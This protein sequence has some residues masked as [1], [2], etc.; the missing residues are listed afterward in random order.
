MSVF[1]RVQIVPI[2]EPPQSMGATY[3][4]W[5]VQYC[6]AARRAGVT[7]LQVNFLALPLHPILCE[8][9]TKVY[10]WFSHYAPSL[11]QFAVSRL[12]RGVYPLPIVAAN[13]ERMRVLA[14]EALRCGLR[15]FLYCAEPRFVPE[16]FFRQRPDLRGPRVDNPVMSGTPCFALCTDKAEVREHYREMLTHILTAIP[17]ITTL[18]LFTTDSGSGFCY[19][20]DLYAGANGPGHCRR[21]PLIERIATFARE[22]IAAGRAINPEF[23]VHINSNL[24]P[25]VRAELARC[26]VDGLCL[27]VYGW[28]SWTGGLED[29]WAYY[30]YRSQIAR[31]GYE[32]ARA[33]RIADLQARVE[34][35]AVHE[36]APWAICSLPTEQY[37]LPLHYVPQPFEILRLLRT[38]RSLGVRNLSLRG[39]MTLPNQVRYDVNAATLP[40]F[41]DN[42]EADDE[43]LVATLVRSWGLERIAAPLHEAWQA[44]DL[45]M[46]RRPNWNHGFGRD[47]HYMVGPL[48][49][50]PARLTV[51]E[52]AYFDHVCFDEIYAIKG[53]LYYLPNLGSLR[54][55]EYVLNQYEAE[56]FP[57]LRQACAVLHTAITQADGEERA[58]LQEQLRYIQIIESHF[59]SQRNWIRMTY[60]MRGGHLPEEARDIVQ[61]EI[62][63]TQA[64]VDLLAG[65]PGRYL[66]LASAKGRMYELD[67]D[68]LVQWEARLL[69]MKRHLDDPLILLSE[70]AVGDGVN[71]PEMEEGTT[72]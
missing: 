55:Y 3:R 30:Q 27:P 63:N 7:E 13:F 72:V 28:Y 35:V 42:P 64:L 49:P 36:Q 37:F 45:A 59:H 56:T 9:P 41:Q 66:M 33:E 15:P 11:D 22:L 50:D 34:A 61:D 67:P 17:Q 12:F 6:A 5:A 70:A 29:Q 2:N 19:N 53:P 69:V 10:H 62:T 26:R 20:S 65:E 52:R 58:C 60:L 16:R 23:Q 57:R 39:L 71:A 1:A 47:E 31:V 32:Q 8:D 4:D 48:V 24:P 46:Q 38:Y 68:V 51:D 14:E 25:A 18:S 54:E 40:A 44:V 21:I 43:T